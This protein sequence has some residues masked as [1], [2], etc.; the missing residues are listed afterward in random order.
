MPAPRTTRPAARYTPVAKRYIRLLGTALTVAVALTALSTAVSARTLRLRLAP[1]HDMSAHTSPRIVAENTIASE[2]DAGSPPVE[3]MTASVPTNRG[4]GGEAPSARAMAAAARAAKA[5]ADEDGEPF[6][7]A[8]AIRTE[9]IGATDAAPAPQPPTGQPVT[10][11][12]QRRAAAGI[13]PSTRV[14]ATPAQPRAGITCIA[15]CY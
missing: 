14:P 3:G 6:E 11:A 4:D 8:G 12:N 9:I 1:G 2:D 15:G 10:A 5:L 7:A 13:T